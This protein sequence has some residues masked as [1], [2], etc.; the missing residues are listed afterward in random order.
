METHTFSFNLKI[1]K[2]GNSKCHLSLGFSGID[3]LGASGIFPAQNA[4]QINGRQ[5]VGVHH[6]PQLK[7][8]IP[9]QVKFRTR[10]SVRR[11]C[12]FLWS[13]GSA[14]VIKKFMNLWISLPVG[15]TAGSKGYAAFPWNSGSPDRL[16]RREDQAK[17]IF[18]EVYLFLRADNLIE[19]TYVNSSK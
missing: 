8:S 14:P 19:L 7:D 10:V 6:C 4:M 9:C 18:Q 1:Y 12:Y 13:K 15:R 11:L 16:E 3:S 2:S 17:K 5:R